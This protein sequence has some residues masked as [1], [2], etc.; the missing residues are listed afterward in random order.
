MDFSMYS[1]NRFPDFVG[2]E[3]GRHPTRVV[4]NYYL[5]A[6]YGEKYNSLL[7]YA[8]VGQ[9][10]VRVFRWDMSPEMHKRKNNSGVCWW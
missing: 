8:S 10:G 9:L 4:G 2:I 7:P 1:I 6:F 3:Y 5:H